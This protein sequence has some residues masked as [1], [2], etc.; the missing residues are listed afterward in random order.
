MAQVNK[1][2]KQQRTK[3]A[4]TKKLQK[5]PTQKAEKTQMTIAGCFGLDISES[6]PS[7]GAIEATGDPLTSKPKGILR[8]AF[9]NINGISIR[10]GLQVMLEIATIGALDIDVA[11]FT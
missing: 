2:K 10:E 7:K 9:Q 5:P 4:K 6:D 8:Y 11:A 3:Q 1:K